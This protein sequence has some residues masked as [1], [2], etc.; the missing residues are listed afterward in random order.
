M[1]SA[2]SMMGKKPQKRGANIRLLKSQLPQVIA[3]PRTTEL[4]PSRQYVA[5]S[6]QQGEDSR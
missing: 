2:T 5:E 4:A 3:Y 6:P 1:Q